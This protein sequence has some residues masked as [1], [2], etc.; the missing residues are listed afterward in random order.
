MNQTYHV[1]VTFDDGSSY[2][3]TFN[4]STK[5]EALNA[6]WYEA[7]LTAKTIADIHIL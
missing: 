1:E 3:H 5:Q 6:A 4:F 7:R 2:V